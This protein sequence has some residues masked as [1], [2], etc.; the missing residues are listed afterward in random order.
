[1]SSPVQQFLCPQCSAEVR[2]E[3]VACPACGLRLK[4]HSELLPRAIA[5]GAVLAAYVWVVTQV[6]QHDRDTGLGLAVLAGLPLCYIFGKAV[7]FRIQGKPL[8]WQQL[9]WTSLRTAAVSLMVMV[10]APVLLGLAVV[11][12]LFVVC[13]GLMMTGKF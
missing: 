6:Y 7:L 4:P 12:L 2:E 3:W 11:L 5:W 9:G 8:T 1:M 10:V 13:G